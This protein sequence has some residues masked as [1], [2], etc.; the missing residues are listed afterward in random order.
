[1]PSFRQVT[2]GI[3]IA[4][5]LAAC[6]RDPNTAKKQYLESGNK[7]LQR[8]RFKEAV[9]QY[10]N[11]VK[12]DPR[13]GPAHYKLGTVYLKLKPPVVQLAIKEYRRAADLLKDNQAYQEE[14]KDSLVQLAQLELTFLYK[15]KQILAE[16]DGYCDALFKKDPNSFDG[17]RLR[18]DLSFVRARLAMAAGNE[19]VYE[20]LLTAAMEDYRK[21]D[22]IKPG[23]AAVSLQMGQI[24]WQQKQ[25][26][27]AEPYFRKVIDKNKSS[28]AAYMDLYR[29]YMVEQKGG[30]AEQLLKEAA[31]NNPKTPEYLVRLAYHYGAAGRRDDMLNVLAQIKSQA[32]DFDGVYQ[33][34]GDFYLRTGDAES[35]LRE[36]REGIVKDA[37]RKSAYQHAIIEV[38]MRQGKRAEAAEVNAQV[39]KENPKDPDAKSLAATFLLDQGDVNTALAQL[40]SVVTSSP[41]NAVAHYQLGR[42]YLYSGRP[43]AREM[44]RT[45][46]ERAINL[47]QDMILPR[48]GLAELQVSH[49]EYQAAFDSAQEILRRD[50]GN[51]SARLIQSQAY[52]GQKKFGESDTLIAAMLK[53]NPS[54]PEVYFQA[55]TAALAQGKPKD[56]EAAFHRAYELNPS[57]PRSLLG[58]VDAMIQEGQ[59]DKAMALLQDEGKKSPNRL[60]IPMLMGV[61][62]QKE[63]KFQESLAY[64]NKVL[65][66][67]DKKA[68]VRADLYLQIA[69]TYRLVGDRDNSIANLQKAREI[70]PENETVLSDLGLVMDQAGRRP[71]ARQAY[72]ACLKVNPNNAL[73]L[74]N[75]AY[76]MAESNADL[77][78]ALNYA[79]KAK[80]LAPNLAEVSD[81]YGWI[82]L[83]KGLAEQAIPV[84]KDL[85]HRVPTDSTFHFHLAKAYQQKA[86]SGKAADELREA[87]K[88]SPPRQEQQEIQTML[89][90]ISGK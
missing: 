50:P 68:K 29:L 71:E 33:V 82:L 43:D 26:A 44:A 27:A 52:L 21:A 70:L 40:Q 41:D 34:V 90:Q 24:L 12:I 59:P 46:F 66:S 1:M 9:I 76:L 79:Q 20:P 23:D 5:T 87:L 54:S 64:F 88:H 81:T 47:R 58:E 25:Y 39:L 57:N 10:Q 11:S 69:E 51:V 18:G 19:T 22:S 55:G 84:F 73:V 49:A 16:V 3:L 4:L 31:Q 63:G 62:A 7:Y 83:K 85:V 2:L 17:F 86:D 30:E 89:T 67:L 45:Q 37:K 32:K 14:Y 60:D 35:A 42:A 28:F 53:A 78:L 75:L 6:R 36:Y 48:L 77:D 61:T 74:N 13:F 72:E 15:D 65:N 8:G 38:L 80:G 56:A